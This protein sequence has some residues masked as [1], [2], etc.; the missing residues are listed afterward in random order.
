MLWH[1]ALPNSDELSLQ[2]PRDAALLTALWLLQAQLP[3]SRDQIKMDAL[4]LSQYNPSVNL[5]ALEAGSLFLC[6]IPQVLINTP[7]TSEVLFMVF[8][9]PLL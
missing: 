3:P 5:L 1:Q 8:V 7:I 4:S 6:G 9:K 2:R